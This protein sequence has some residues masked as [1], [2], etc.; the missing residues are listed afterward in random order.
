M[1][2]IENQ[3]HDNFYSQQDCQQK[4]K[5]K[6]VWI[7]II[8]NILI[9]LGLIICHIIGL[10][11]KSN[12]DKDISVSKTANNGELTIAFVRSDTLWSNYDFVKY[13][14]KILDSIEVKYQS[15]YNYQAE[16]LQS[17][18]NEYIKKGTAGLLSLNQQKETENKLTQR[19]NDLIKLDE[20]LSEEL[21]AQKEELNN[22]LQDTILNFI[23][24]YNEKANYT[25]ILEYAK[26]SGILYADEAYDITEDIVIGLNNEYKK[27]KAKIE[28]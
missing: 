27:N 17:D 15:Q 10:A 24:R 3:M 14:K 4:P 16:K 25:Y 20:R 2:E 23:K 11:E 8:L 9:I 18:Y 26:L 5:N 6:L 22:V 1:N 19:Q 21:L 12:D 7:S 13:S 28:N